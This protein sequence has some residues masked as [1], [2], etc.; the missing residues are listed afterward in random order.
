M[1]II[2]DEFKR[3]AQRPSLLNP[4]VADSAL[5][6]APPPQPAAQAP[7]AALFR[8]PV[9][10]APMREPATAAEP[11]RAPPGA[12]LTRGSTPAP[13]NEFNMARSNIAEAAAA[14]DALGEAISSRGGRVPPAMTRAEFNTAMPSAEPG[15]PDTAQLLRSRSAP[16]VPYD[17]NAP[18]GPL[19]AAPLADPT[20]PPTSDLLRTRSAP[21]L[22]A[23]P[24]TNIAAAA[25]QA[26]V[27][28]NRTPSPPANNPIVNPN[29]SRVGAGVV[30]NEGY[31][32]EQSGAGNKIP[33]QVGNP[34]L[35]PVPPQGVPP[36]GGFGP[37]AAGSGPAVPNMPPMSSRWPSRWA[38]ACRR[39]GPRR[40]R[41]ACHR[42]P[43]HR[44][45]RRCLLVRQQVLPQRL[46]AWAAWRKPPPKRCRTSPPAP[47]SWPE[48][49]HRL[50]SLPWRD[51]KLP[52]WRPI[53]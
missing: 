5:L 28:P 33:N 47:N 23:N 19:N 21:P 16:P 46:G 43:C 17:I 3:S 20:I 26:T 29:V 9:D 41:E 25:Q 53:L 14:P 42:E 7:A 12:A 32:Y 38:R 40:H 44:A 52:K 22:A 8:A 15:V 31:N 24:A 35:N 50:R 6:R 51:T 1:G 30:S 45:L 11:G 39:R 27:A 49:W 2:E 34:K 18:G 10:D 4:P 48:G 37:R 36:Q 13:V